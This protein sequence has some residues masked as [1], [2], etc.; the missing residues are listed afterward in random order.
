MNLF[1]RNKSTPADVT[2]SGPFGE[3]ALRHKVAEEM[4]L[5]A[6][7]QDLGSASGRIIAMC[8]TVRG[9][10]ASF[11]AM[12]LATAIVHDTG[13]SVCLVDCDW[14]E[15]AGDENIGLA[16]Y[17]A[18]MVDADT[19]VQPTSLDGLSY[20]S[21]GAVPL[22]GRA[23]AA[24]SQALANLMSD[25]SSEYEIVLLDVPPLSDSAHALSLARLADE[26]LVIVRQGGV[27]IERIEQVMG[28]LGED[29]VSGI[30]LNDAKI[31]SPA[32]LVSPLIAG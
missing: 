29:H 15:E 16:G 17:L 25:L 8:S 10:G 26:S 5:L 27:P 21:A 32:W 12:S 28:D 11:V 4:R 31:R 23:P 7:R 19:F 22:A 2:V 24:N 9:E 18:G 6:R 1:G 20:V 13:R 3:F 30:V 14:T